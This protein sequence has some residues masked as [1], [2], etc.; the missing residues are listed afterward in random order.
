MSVYTVGKKKYIDCDIPASPFAQEGM[1]SFWDGDKLIGIP[2][3]QLER[4]ELNF[5]DQS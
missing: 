3:A 5:N 4:I 1:V 2:V